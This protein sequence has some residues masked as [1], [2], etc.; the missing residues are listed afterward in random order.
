MILA[1]IGLVAGVITWA[2]SDSPEQN[3]ARHASGAPDPAHDVWALIPVYGSIQQIKEA[4]SYFQ[5]VLGVGFLMLDCTSS[6]TA[7]IAAVR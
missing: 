3:A 7:G 4:D 1:G 5:R 6:G 2:L